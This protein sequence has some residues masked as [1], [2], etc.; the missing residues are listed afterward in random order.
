MEKKGFIKRQKNSRGITLIRSYRLFP[1]LGQ[2]AAG[3]P[4]DAQERHEGNLRLEA[5]FD[6]EK[7]FVIRVKGQSMR[8]AG[9]CEGDF[10]IVR[11]Q[12]SV[13]HGDMAVIIINGCA[14]IKQILFQN[15]KIILRAYNEAFEDIILEKG[16]EN[17]ISGKL[18]GIVR[19]L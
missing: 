6:P 11:Q 13:E 15:D 3:F 14:T 19:K 18:V 17:I 10:A 2:V 12:N 1:I 9:I 5:L 8:D 4:I 7:C 16:S